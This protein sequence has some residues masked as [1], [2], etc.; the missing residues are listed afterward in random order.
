MQ[1]F[2]N[3]SIYGVLVVGVFAVISTLLAESTWFSSIGINSLVIAIILG[4]L[5]SNTYHHR[6]PREWLPGIQFSAKRL[7]RL[8]IILYGFRVSFQQIIAVG[9]PGLILDLFIVCFT[10]L[11]GTIIGVRILKLDRHLALLISIGASIC[12]AAAVLA[13]EEILKNEPHKTTVAIGTVVLFGTSA[14]FI[15]PFIQKM[16]W[17]GF[18]E[19]Q[20]GL[21]AGATIHEVAQVVVAGNEI[22]QNAGSIAI[23]VKM[24]RVLLLVPLLILL[25]LYENR[26]SAKAH[27]APLKLNIPWFA[28]YFV[29]IIGF[30]SL[31]LLPET[32]VNYINRFDIFL[33]TMAMAAIGMETN[34]AKIKKV[35]VT[36]LYL[37]ALLFCWLTASGYTLVKFLT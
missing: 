19:K 31:H 18:D 16:G 10:L 13:S 26:L 32:W 33:L 29:F 9:I 7:L 14:M 36:P 37:A 12:G 4:I 3:P 11:L 8:A 15:Y 2:I 27:H 30:N 22:S 17:F 5:Y 6:L 21:F 28:I 1:K 34:L 25:S 35:G 20:F 24:T 23:I